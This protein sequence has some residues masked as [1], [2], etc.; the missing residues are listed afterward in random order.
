M[1]G[2]EAA[3]RIREKE[4]TRSLPIVLISAYAGKE[5]EARC[6]EVGV[7]VFLQK[8][9]T[10]SSLFN[11]IVEAQGLHSANSP[12]RVRHILENEFEGTVALLAE[13]NE[14][15]QMVAT[16]LLS[17]LGIELDIANNGRE[18]VEMA[19]EN[20]G[21]YAAILMDMQ[22]PEM[23]GLEATRAL[24]A[25][26]EFRDLPI[27]AM[28][29]NA[30][31]QDLDACLAAG[32]NDH[33]VKPI[34]RAVLVADAPALVAATRASVPSSSTTRSAEKVAT[35]SHAGPAAEEVRF[36]ACMSSKESRSKAALPQAGSCPSRACGRC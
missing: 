11:A 3:S 35:R 25:D 18:A 4:E 29:A 7:N 2:L 22:M 21:R 30:M 34:D 1:N 28:T 8:P 23:D 9:I 16:E 17:R 5:E 12:S 19:R 10:A 6:A 33:V 26:P 36:Q 31:R 13:D 14:A 15:N 32:M 27:I 20:K 24:R